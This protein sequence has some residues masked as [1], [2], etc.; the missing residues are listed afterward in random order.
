MAAGGLAAAAFPAG[1]SRAIDP[2]G[3]AVLDVPAVADIDG[4]PIAVEG[5]GGPLE[6]AT[7]PAGSAN[8]T[9]PSPVESVYRIVPSVRPASEEAARNQGKVTF[10]LAGI[11]ENSDTNLVLRY[12]SSVSDPPSLP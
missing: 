11:V 9:A 6:G 8:R 3:I 1:Q 7:N 2:V 10:Q 5:I 12:P 4:G